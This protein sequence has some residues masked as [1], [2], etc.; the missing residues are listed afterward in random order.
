[1]RAEHPLEEWLYKARDGEVLV[2]L[3]FRPAG[4][5]VTDEHFARAGD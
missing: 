1:M 3:I 5:P 4:G 2:D